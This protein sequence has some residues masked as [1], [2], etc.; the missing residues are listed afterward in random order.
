MKRI[1][2]AVIESSGMYPLQAFYL[3]WSLREFAGVANKDIKFRYFPRSNYSQVFKPLERLGIEL[4]P[5]KENKLYAHPWCRKIIGLNLL[6]AYEADE[7]VLLDC[8]IIVREAPH[9]IQGFIQAKP[10][11]FANPPL[12]YLEEI[13]SLGGL[14]LKKAESDIDKSETAFGNC[15]GGVYVIPASI[16]GRLHNAWGS[17]AHWCLDNKEKFGK[18]SMHVDQVAFAMAV[19]SEKLP[20]R[21]LSKEDNFPVHVE[22]NAERDC[23][24]NVIHYHNALDEQMF[25]KKLGN[26]HK[27]NSTIEDINRGLLKARSVE[28]DNQLFW[29][30]RY[31]IYPGLG[32][33]LGSRGDSLKYKQKVIQQ[34]IKLHSCKKVLDICSG[35]G[36]VMKDISTNL[37]LLAFDVSECSK[38]LYLQNNPN[39]EWTLLDITK[40]KPSEEGDLNICLDS[41]IHLSQKAQ[42]EASVKNICE[43]V[44]PVLVS[45][46]NEAP[47]EFGP[48]TYFHESLADTIHRFGRAM[49]IIGK[50]RDV[51][52]FYLHPR[53][54]GKNKRDIKNETLNLAS[55]FIACPFRLIHVLTSSKNTIGF[56]PDQTSRCIEYPWFIE[57]IENLKPRSLV[58]VGSGVSV[59]PILSAR[60]GCSVTT[61]DNH[62]MKRT[63]ESKNEWDEWGF[64]DY[65]LFH[66]AIQSLRLSFEQINPAEKADMVISISVIEHI[67]ADLRKTWIKHAYQIL[68]NH[69]VLLLSIDTVPFSQKLWNRSQGLLVEDEK[70]HGTIQDLVNELEDTGFLVEEKVYHEQLPSS[71]TGLLMMMLRKTSEG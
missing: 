68:K 58:D 5:I 49:L 31:T 65:S 2:S 9:S 51:T 4:I 1:Y 39:A 11:D 21:E 42:Y 25:L 18:Y 71:K 13:Y 14:R 40:D 24:P 50:Y 32:S 64:L 19:S 55:P 37:R 22:Q 62:P 44:G 61:I 7:F 29:N 46:F 26:L 70:L 34:I 54:N 52:L 15:N 8:D 60:L 27:V 38:K 36:E 48:M 3:A 67:P 57:K 63:Q 53:S 43:L 12:E 35:D 17:W 56:F 20:F 16:F 6:E 30:A 45:G 59:V 41:L 47:S 23:I 10:V 33:G 66:Q 69:G 28:F